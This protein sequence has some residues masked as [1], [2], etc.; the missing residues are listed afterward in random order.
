[1]CLFIV[2]LYISLCFCKLNNIH[3]N[4][5]LQKMHFSQSLPKS[6]LSLFYL[7]FNQLLLI[8]Y[9]FLLS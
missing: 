2:L 1:M 9:T 3:L 5:S 7:L 6:L 4:L 8:A